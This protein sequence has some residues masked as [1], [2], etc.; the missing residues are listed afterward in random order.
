M[1]SFKKTLSFFGVIALFVL[2]PAISLAGNLELYAKNACNPCA[3]NACNP[4]GRNACNPC[5]KGMKNACN[6]C[7]KNA[8]NPCGKR[9]K[10]ACNPCNPCASKPPKPIRDKHI[11][12]YSKLVAMGEKLWKN[13][14]LGNSGLSCWDCHED[15][16]NFDQ[17]TVG[18]FPH[19]VNMPNDIV[20]LDQMINFCMIN[21]MEGKKLDSSSIEMTAIA[22][23]Y[24]EFIKEYKPF[25]APKNACNPCGK[26]KMRNACNPCGKKRKNA[27]NPCNP[28]G[29]R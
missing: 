18:P 1:E 7:A 25:V 11:T 23:F 5:G 21:P 14:E 20:T 29:K 13:V 22:A 26:K 6:P 17:E 28:C 15:Y 10:N 16:E 24:R 27:C 9:M 2:I 8:C 19:F 3:K 12:N 4:C